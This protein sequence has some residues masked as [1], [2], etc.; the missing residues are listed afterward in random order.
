MQE[1]RIKV[2]SRSQRSHRIMRNE[3]VVPNNKKLDLTARI[4]WIKSTSK[5]RPGMAIKKGKSYKYN[6]INVLKVYVVCTIVVIVTR[7]SIIDV[8]GRYI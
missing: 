4:D 2:K 3:L 6:Y 8:V 5:G 7:S 1:R